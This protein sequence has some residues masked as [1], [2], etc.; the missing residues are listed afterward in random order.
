MGDFEV[1]RRY[2]QFDVLRHVMFSRFMGLYVPPLPEKK[3]IGSTEDFFVEERTYFLNKF[4]QDI[5]GL[6]Y[7]YESQEFQTFLRPSGADLEQCFNQLP[8]LTTE[9]QLE[10]FREVLPVNEG[11]SD[12]NRLKRYND[13]VINGFVRDC[14]AL[15]Q[16]LII[17]KNQMKVVV[18]I[19]E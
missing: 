9:M 1:L 10:R 16:A 19:K 11:V 13:D 17:F 3:A 4:M 12:D 2:K 5:S 14:N 6:P 18:P 8:I 15:L 7:L